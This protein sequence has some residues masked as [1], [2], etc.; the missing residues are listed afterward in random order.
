MERKA[1][2]FVISINNISSMREKT[3]YMGDTAG[4]GR[5]HAVVVDEQRDLVGAAVLG[6]R[7]RTQSCFCGPREDRRDLAPGDHHGLSRGELS[8][9]GEKDPALL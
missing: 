7:R 6:V 9:P 1:S 8:S 2:H 5:H 3:Q 4:A